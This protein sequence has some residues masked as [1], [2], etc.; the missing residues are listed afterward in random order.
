MTESEQARQHV[1]AALEKFQRASAAV[2]SADIEKGR[3]AK[4]LAE[5]TD[6]ERCAAENARPAGEFTARVRDAQ[7]AVRLHSY[8]LGKLGVE[9]ESKRIDWQDRETRSRARRTGGGTLARAA[10]AA[11][12]LLSSLDSAAQDKETYLQAISDLRAKASFVANGD[13]ATLLVSRIYSALCGAI[14]TRIL[15]Q[16]LYSGRDYRGVP[17]E[18]AAD[19]RQQIGQQHSPLIR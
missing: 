16:E 12:K 10:A 11:D 14:V 9:A 5:A 17:I 7:D 2:D 8:R 3:L 6:A 1:A 18:S 15:D 4:V 13:P 19:I